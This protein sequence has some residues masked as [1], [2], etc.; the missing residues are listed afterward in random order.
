MINVLQYLKPHSSNRA[1]SA[2][3]LTRNNL[4]LNNTSLSG[5]L[6]SCEIKN[7]D[8]TLSNR[9][10]GFKNRELKDIK[11]DFL[12]SN[13]RMLILQMPISMVSNLILKLNLLIKLKV[14]IS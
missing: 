14:I 3:D 13:L 11:F 8:V 2:P 1:L 10:K 12:V 4:S 7:K 9:N 5:N 6:L